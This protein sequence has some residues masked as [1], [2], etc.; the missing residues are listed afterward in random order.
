MTFA[1]P[2]RRG[3]E[4][5]PGSIR[6][7]LTRT[8]VGVR[9]AVAPPCCSLFPQY[10]PQTARTIH[11]GAKL[12]GAAEADGFDGALDDIFELQDQVA[13][14]VVGAIEPRLRQSEFDR[15]SRKPTESL[16]AYEERY[17]ASPIASRDTRKASLVR[18]RRKSLAPV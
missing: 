9:T 4:T 2:S 16:D 11:D 7:A 17:E 5:C 18:P 1:H 8:S 12:I 3:N 14:G 10:E 15:A 6:A 13:S